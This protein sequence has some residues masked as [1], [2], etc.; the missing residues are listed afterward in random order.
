VVV[1]RTEVTEGE[2]ELAA[3]RAA[4]ARHDWQGALDEARAVAFDDPATEADRAD[5]E[6]EAA[7]WLG[8]LEDCISARE[9]AYRLYDELGDQRRA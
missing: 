4:I 3:T 7:W 5:L 9:R 6:A 1:G 8:R 2:D